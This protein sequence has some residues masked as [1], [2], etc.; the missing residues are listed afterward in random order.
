MP[1]LRNTQQRQIIESILQKT[2]RP[3][4]PKELLTIAQTHLP[5]MGIATVF[6]ALKD[7]VKEGVV[8]TVSINDDPL[9]YEG[10]RAHHH[11]FKCTE[12]NRV[13]DVFRCTGNIEQLVPSG[14]TLMEHEITL[15][16][17]CADCSSNS[18]HSKQCR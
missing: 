13:Y 5:T 11:H 7:L 17:Q 12:C 8:H 3:L 10:K 6:R 16:G 9:R 15:Y 4:L 18:A 1:Q 2:D 14:F